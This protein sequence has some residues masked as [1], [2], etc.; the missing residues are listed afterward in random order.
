MYAAYKAG[1]EH[2]DYDISPKTFTGLEECVV[3]ETGP[4]THAAAFVNPQSLTF[5]MIDT[6][7]VQ[8]LCRSN[9]PEITDFIEAGNFYMI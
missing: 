3:F 1:I 8:Y 6:T 4:T 5:F 2:F 7:H 9:M